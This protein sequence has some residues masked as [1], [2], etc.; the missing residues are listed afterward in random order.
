V[1]A[2]PLAARAQAP[3]HRPLIMDGGT[4]QAAAFAA[5]ASDDFAGLIDIDDRSEAQCPKLGLMV[6]RF[7]IVSDT[8]SPLPFAY[9]AVPMRHPRKLSERRWRP[10]HHV[11]R[12]TWIRQTPSR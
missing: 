2:W 11:V 10:P 1:G 3:A 5:A 4:A 12:W 7:S 9:R 6:R 8:S